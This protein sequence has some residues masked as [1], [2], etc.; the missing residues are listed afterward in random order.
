MAKVP[1]PPCRQYYEEHPH[2]APSRSK[3]A[4][5]KRSEICI[6]CLEKNL[7][8]EDFHDVDSLMRYLNLPFMLDKW[9]LL[10]ELNGAKTLRTYV[11]M[12]AEAGEYADNLVDWS[13]YNEQWL[14]MIAEGTLGQE[15]PAFGDK[16]MSDMK[17]KW[18]GADYSPEEFVYLEDL[19]NNLLKSQNILPGL[20][21]SF[22]LM[23]CQL[24]LKANNNLRENKPIKEITAEIKNIMGLAGFETKGSKNTGDF[25]TMGELVY[26][27][28]KTGWQPRYAVAESKDEVD[29]VIKDTQAFLRRLVLGEPGLADQVQQRKEAYIASKQLESEVF[30]DEKQFDEYESSLLSGSDYEGEVDL[31]GV[32]DE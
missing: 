21:Q 4:F 7:N 14:T 16:W 17:V 25:D 26:W 22:A 3:W 18:Q 11:K 28:E 30:M 31:E 8:S 15:I 27:L 24:I 6:Y 10:Y 2:F 12:F 20:S 5:H 13:Y 32:D 19:Y 1:C 29:I 23:L 9:M